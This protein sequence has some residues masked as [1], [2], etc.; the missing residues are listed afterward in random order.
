[1]IKKNVK[2][3][4]F[5]FYL[6]SYFEIVYLDNS[7]LIY[8]LLGFILNYKINICFDMKN[9]IMLKEKVFICYF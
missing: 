3:I 6:L 7:I 1:M 4:I 2:S 9:M 5:K 8:L